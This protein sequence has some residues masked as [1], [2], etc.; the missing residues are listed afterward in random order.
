MVQSLFNSRLFISLFLLLLAGKGVTAQAQWQFQ[1][2]GFN[3]ILTGITFPGNQDSIGYAVGMSST[4]NGSGIILKTTDAGN[5]W[6]QLNS[7]TL[8]GLETVFFSSVDTGYIGGWQNYFAKTTNGGLTWT[9][10]VVNANIW[11]IKEI[12]FFNSQ[13]G[14]VVAAGSEAYVTNNG[15]T[16]WTAASGFINAEDIT[17]VS[18]DTLYAVGGDEKIARSV[19]GGL[20]WTTIYSGTFQNVFL[21][22]DFHGANRGLVVG[23]DGK[24]LTT[25]NGGNSWSVGFVG[26]THLLRVAHMFDSLNYLA[27]GTP[28]GVYV[29]NNGGLSWSLDFQGGN[30]Y[31]LYTAAFIPS[32]SGFIS[33]SQ[34]R[35]LKKIV[36]LTAGF[37]VNSDSICVGDSVLFTHNSQGSPTNWQWTFFGGNPA[38][39]NG[40]Q[41]PAVYYSTPGFHDVQLIVSNAS[42]ADTLYQTA[43]LHVQTVNPV[44]IGN[45]GPA[46][47]G[48]TVAYQVAIQPNHTYTWNV[49]GGQI[50][51]GQGSREIR[52]FWPQAANGLVRVRVANSIGCSASDSLQVVVNASTSSVSDLL[53]SSWN[54]YPNPASTSLHLDL[55][56]SMQMVKRVRIYDMLGRKWADLPFESTRI[57]VE[58]LPAGAYMLEIE[59]HGRFSRKRFIKQ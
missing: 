18:A 24:V 26:G 52:V 31:A 11:Y 50:I 56:S 54:I 28:E 48:D 45:G 25:T 10:S 6:T 1:N 39:F 19:N 33:G 58:H 36:S 34:G 17:Y 15:G 14:I 37:S 57:L 47:A 2:T 7:A 12:N 23:E 51:A 59:Q 16:S 46:T 5:T 20:N 13:K 27:A 42:S 30:N 35:I 3:F 49:Q 38:T 40:P 55:P 8:P 41:T 32:G 44:S 21:G 53:A 22:V 29:S 9:S 4:Y 43:L